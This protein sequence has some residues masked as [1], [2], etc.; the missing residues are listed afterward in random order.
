M[1]WGLFQEVNLP[2]KPGLFWLVWLNFQLIQYSEANTHIHSLARSLFTLTFASMRNLE[3]QINLTCVSLDC[4][5]KPEYPPHWHGENIQAPHRKAL[6]SM[7]TSRFMNPGFSCCKAKPLRQF[8]NKFNIILAQKP[9]LSLNQSSP[10]TV[11]R[12]NLALSQLAAGWTVV[13]ECHFMAR[14]KLLLCCST[15]NMLVLW[16]I[17]HI[18]RNND[19]KQP[20]HKA[21]QDG[22]KLSSLQTSKWLSS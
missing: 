19:G 21:Q 5:E 7:V 9:K 8:W 12:P 18:S 10:Y 1:V 16:L 3:W 20:E 14:G 4:G 15:A 13:W 17:V 6:P 2:N 11:F 22:V